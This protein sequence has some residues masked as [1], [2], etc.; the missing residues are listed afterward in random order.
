MS[1][2]GLYRSNVSTVWIPRPLNRKA[3]LAAHREPSR[4]P[5]RRPLRQNEGAKPRPLSYFAAG[6]AA[7]EPRFRPPL[8]ADFFPLLLLL[9]PAAGPLAFFRALRLA[10]SA[11]FASPA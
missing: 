9:P 7:A 6:A 8:P 4:T 11:V 10:C 3:V 5:L 2:A 1:S